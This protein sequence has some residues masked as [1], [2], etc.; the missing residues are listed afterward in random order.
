M[1]APCA[2]CLAPCKHRFGLRQPTIGSGAY[3]RNAFAWEDGSAKPALN[4]SGQAYE[5]AGY[6]HWGLYTGGPSAG[7]PNNAGGSNQQCVASTASH[8]EFAYYSGAFTSTARRNAANYI[9]EVNDSLNVWSWNDR[10][11]SESY[12]YICEFDG[13]QLAQRLL[14]PA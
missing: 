3:N 4:P 11:C 13:E 10:V 2:H 8:T 7:E 1:L 5:G 14:L 9:K 6:S 12:V